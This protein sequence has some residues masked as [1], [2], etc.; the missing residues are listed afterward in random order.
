MPPMLVDVLS[1][2]YRVTA[3]KADRDFVFAH[4]ERGSALDADWYRERFTEALAA[5]GIEG[6][7]RTFHDMRHTAL[8]NLALTPQASELVL[9]TTAGH[10]S[11]ATTKQYL[12]LAGRVFPEAAAGLQDRMFGVESSTHLR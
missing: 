10:R 9:M 12:Q 11:F 5:A 7:V 3:Y 6:R 4:P 1:E 2:R 8:T